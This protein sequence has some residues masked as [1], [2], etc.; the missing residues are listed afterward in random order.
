M[1]RIFVHRPEQR[2]NLRPWLDQVQNPALRWLCER[3]KELEQYSTVDLTPHSLMAVVAVA[4]PHYMQQVRTLIRPNVIIDDSQG[5][6]D[7]IAD[8]MCLET[9]PELDEPDSDQPFEG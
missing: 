8:I 9:T 7:H 3:L 5:V 1:I 6:I 2:D 4:E